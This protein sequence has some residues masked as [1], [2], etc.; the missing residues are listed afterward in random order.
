MAE[1]AQE[2]WRSRAFCSDSSRFAVSLSP[3][4]PISVADVKH[5]P[6]LGFALQAD[7]ALLA[8]VNSAVMDAAELTSANAVAG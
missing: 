1:K 6:A 4:A 3:I 2:H 5:L 7:L 8:V